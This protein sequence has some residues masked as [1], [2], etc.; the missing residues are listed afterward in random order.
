MI[1]IQ[2]SNYENAKAICVQ[3]NIEYYSNMLL[4]TA[5]DTNVNDKAESV[6]GYCLFEIEDDLSQILKL[7]I[8]S[9]DMFLIA[10]GILRTTINFLLDH[11][12]KKAI[13]KGSKYLIF[14][15]KLGF[16]EQ[17][18]LYLLDICEDIFKSCGNKLFTVLESDI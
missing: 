12:I 18:G 16:K 7:N 4:Y 17:E 5:R 15:K 11:G 2:L 3:N 9:Q 13:Y 6:L 8:N 10:D 14:F 1:E